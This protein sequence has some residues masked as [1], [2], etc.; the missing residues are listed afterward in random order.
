MPCVTWT[1]AWFWTQPVP[2][3][4][5][6][7]GWTSGCGLPGEALCKH[8]TLHSPDG[9]T[10]CSKKKKKSHLKAWKVQSTSCSQCNHSRFTEHTPAVRPFDNACIALPGFISL[11]VSLGSPPNCILHLWERILS[12]GHSIDSLVTYSHHTLDISQLKCFKSQIYKKNCL[13]MEQ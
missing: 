4:Q 3:V 10:Y 12:S 7:V 2:A 13:T 6:P 8:Q 1:W 5:C 9:G 11:L